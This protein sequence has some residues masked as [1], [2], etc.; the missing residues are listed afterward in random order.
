MTARCGVYC[1]ICRQA[2]VPYSVDFHMVI[3]QN[4]QYYGLFT[5][6]EDT[7]DQFLMVSLLHQQQQ[8]HAF[9]ALPCSVLPCPALPCL[10]LP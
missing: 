8:Q 9:P 1:G 3:R 2:G 4:G 6:V 7:D 5:F 10:A